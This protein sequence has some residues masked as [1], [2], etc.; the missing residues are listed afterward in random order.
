MKIFIWVILGASSL[1]W[2]LIAWLKGISIGDYLGLILLI[3]NVV[4]ADA[5][6]IWIFTKWGWKWGLFQ[7]WLVPF[8]NLNGIWEGEIQSTWVDPQTGRPSNPIAA[9]LTIK[10]SFLNISCVMRTTEMVSYS[11][12][13]DFRIDEERQIKQLVYSYLSSPKLTI[14]D[15]SSLHEGTIV[16]NIMG[17]PANKL[18]GHYW[19]SRKTTGEIVLSF[20]QN[21]LLNQMPA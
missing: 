1:F 15:R 10:Q 16:F 6:M 13:E 18:D 12:A 5:I 17:N 8:P 9:L 7:G 19:T 11:Y 4:T 2:W 3:P 20:K 21:K 14:S